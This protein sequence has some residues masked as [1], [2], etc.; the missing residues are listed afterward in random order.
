VSAQRLWGRLAL[1][2]HYTRTNRD[3]TL[4][5]DAARAYADMDDDTLTDE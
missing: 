2:P 5:S 3:Y 4:P 1:H